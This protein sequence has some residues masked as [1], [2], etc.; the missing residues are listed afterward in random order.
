MTVLSLSLSLF[1]SLIVLLTLADLIWICVRPD[2]VNL[3]GLPVIL[4][5][6]PLLAYRI[7]NRF[8]PLKEGISFL[9]GSEYSPWWGSYQF[10]LIYITFPC[11]ESLLRLI[12]G[13]F[14]V[15][16]RLWG[17]QIGRNVIWTPALQVSDRGFLQVGDRVI[18][19]HSVG[20]YCHIIKPKRNNLM[21]YLRSI[22]IGR[23]TFVGAG[24]RLA[25]GAEIE[26]GSYLP[27]LTDVYPNRRRHTQEG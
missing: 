19:G 2:P 1:P 26:A 14:S 22:K 16:L 17:S 5:G 13:A 15:W 11:L 7:H 18:F 3:M 6:L 12:P 8:F 27:I 9:V 4:Y 24:S 21:L 10:Q 23:D 20:L 25:A